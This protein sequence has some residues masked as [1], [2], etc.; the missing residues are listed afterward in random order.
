MWPLSCRVRKPGLWRCGLLRVVQWQNDPTATSAFKCNPLLNHP[1]AL[2]DPSATF[3]TLAPHWGEG[4]L[5]FHM[6]DYGPHDPFGSQAEGT[7]RASE[8]GCMWALHGFEPPGSGVQMDHRDA[9]EV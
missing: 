2:E 8:K 4:G 7:C 9:K 6:V 5:Q 3:H 1:C